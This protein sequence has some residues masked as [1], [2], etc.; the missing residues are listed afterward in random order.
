MENYAN[1]TCGI[2]AKKKKKR[3]LHALIYNIFYVSCTFGALV[4]QMLP[5]DTVFNTQASI[6]SY[7]SRVKSQ[8][9]HF[10]S[11]QRYINQMGRKREEEKE[12]SLV[13]ASFGSHLNDRIVDRPVYL[14]RASSLRA[15]NEVDGCS[16]QG[17][18]RTVLGG[19]F[20]SSSAVWVR[21]R[22]ARGVVVN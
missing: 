7:Y 9:R 20:W 1:S 18:A 6:V 4:N 3:Q 12:F 11:R 15:L 2:I 17:G 8:G 10:T 5:G 14:L 13:L 21:W 19:S 16:Q 22:K